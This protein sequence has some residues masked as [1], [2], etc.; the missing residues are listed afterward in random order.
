ML[1]LAFDADELA[2]EEVDV[3]PDPLDKLLDPLLPPILRT[4][5]EPGTMDVR[6]ANCL[7]PVAAATATAAAAL[8]RLVEFDRERIG[9]ELAKLAIP[10]LLVRLPVPVTDPMP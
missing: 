1:P 10:A 2:P 4:L 9:D 7:F 8:K 3:D 6:W 5:N